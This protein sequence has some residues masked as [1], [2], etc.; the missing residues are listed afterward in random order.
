MASEDL[1]QSNYAALYQIIGHLA[2]EAGVFETEEV[3]RFLTDLQAMVEGAQ[4]DLGEAHLAFAPK[5]SK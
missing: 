5:A 1:H 2:G 4:I 3:G